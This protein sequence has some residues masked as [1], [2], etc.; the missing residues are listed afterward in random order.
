MAAAY[1][2]YSLWIVPPAG[3]EA[4]AV[5]QAAIEQ[6]SAAQGVAPFAPHMTLVG[7]LPEGMDEDEVCAGAARIAALTPPY[8]V[9]GTHVDVLPDLVFRCVF[10]RIAESAPVLAA[11]ATAVDEYRLADLPDFATY[12]PHVS[13]LYADIDL[14]ARSAAAQAIAPHVD[15][16]EFEAT[17]LQVW[18]TG[19]PYDQ[20]AMVAEYPLTG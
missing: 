4:E 9:R 1:K 12:M 3:S 5:L 15:G 10:L 19:G 11:F 20:W 17:T 2:G 14:A 8:T 6:A 18:N 7:A 13:L 16:V